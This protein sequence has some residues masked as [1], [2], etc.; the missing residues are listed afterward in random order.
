MNSSPLTG[1]GWGWLVG[2]SIAGVSFGAP[3]PPEAAPAPAMPVVSNAAAAVPTL[4]PTISSIP[5]KQLVAEADAL[6]AAGK[7]SD[8]RSRYLAALDAGPADAGRATVEEKLGKLNVEL[9]RMPWAMSGKTNYTVQAGDSV[10]AIA[11]SFGT[12]VDLIV[13]S[14]ELKRPDL[15]K[16]GDRL[17]VFAEKLAICVNKSRN[18]LLVTANG[19][20]FK[21][22]R[23]GTGRFD[24][25]PTGTFAV[26]DR[27]ME[28]VWWRPDGKTILYGDKENILGTRWLALQATGTTEAIK[29]YGIHGTWDDSS[30]G[31][32]ESSGCIRLKNADVEELFVLVPVGTAVT[33]EE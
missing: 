20:F 9:V 26:A 10:R 18:D 13:E 28:P 33:I 1:M 32:A 14:N 24:R 3:L 23:V 5:A 22:Y 29:G 11:Q 27:I 12:T 25:T 2:I 16:P 17:R 4:A 21:R 30:I 19:R 7:R 15:I 6:L 8:A 31:K